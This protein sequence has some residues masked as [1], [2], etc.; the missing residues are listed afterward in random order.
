MDIYEVLAQWPCQIRYINIYYSG[1]WFQ[2]GLMMCQHIDR[3]LPIPH[4]AYFNY[5]SGAQYGIVKL[6]SSKNIHFQLK[7]SSAFI[8]WQKNLIIKFFYILSDVMNDKNSFLFRVHVNLKPKYLIT[9]VYN[10]VFESNT[11]ILIIFLLH[12]K[13]ALALAEW[14]IFHLFK[15]WRWPLINRQSQWKFIRIWMHNVCFSLFTHSNEIQKNYS[16]EEFCI[17]ILAVY[18]FSY[19]F[20]IEICAT[21]KRF[22]DEKKRLFPYRIHINYLFPRR[23]HN[24]C[25]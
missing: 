8:S 13:V 17:K 1:I 18:C 20:H 15:Y 6:A 10:L 9:L 11:A 19:F 16:S 4:F 12:P 7:H 22:P 2:D 3:I 25:V 21:E 5:A 24:I 23:S 14:E